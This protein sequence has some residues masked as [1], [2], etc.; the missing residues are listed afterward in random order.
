M[1]MMTGLIELFDTAIERCDRAYIARDFARKL[2]VDIVKEL[3]Y[4][5]SGLD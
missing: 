1:V 4:G 5:W 3:E 2:N